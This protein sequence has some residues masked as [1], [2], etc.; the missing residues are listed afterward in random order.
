MLKQKQMLRFAQ[1]DKQGGP[2]VYVFMGHY[3]S[4]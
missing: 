1:H 2:F 4:S 3:T